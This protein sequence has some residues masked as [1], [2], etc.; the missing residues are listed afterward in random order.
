M[1]SSL[2]AIAKARHVSVKPGD[3]VS[4]AGDVLT[5]GEGKPFSA[6]VNGEDLTGDQMDSYKARPRDSIE[7]DD[8][9]DIM[10]DYDVQ[11]QEQQ[12]V[13]KMEGS[14]GAVAYVEQWGQV[15]KVEQRTG[16]T[17]G[18][19]AE[20]D[21]LQEKKDCVIRA[22]N[23]HPADGQRLVALTFDDGPSDP[24]TE[25]YL[26]ILQQYDAK[27]TFFCLGENIEKYPELAKR[28]TDAGMQLCSHTDTHQDLPSLSSS[29]L[30]E[31]INHT[32]GTIKDATGQETTTIRPPY[33][34]FKEQTWLDSRGT[35]S[36][37]ITWNMD[38][39]DWS[40]PGAE[41]IVSNATTGIQPGYIILMHDGGGDRSQDVEALPQ[42][43]KTLQDQGYKFV[44]VSEL[45]ASEGD[46][47]SDVAR[48]DAHMPEGAVWPD[49]ISPDDLKATAA[50][51]S[52]SSSTSS[53]SSSSS[54][55]ESDGE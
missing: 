41:A 42:I 11:V 19:T 43:I 6:K 44:T 33:G 35:I 9:A 55:S 21:T 12:P 17:S 53:S 18:K 3:Y 13:L 20:G 27:A 10:E 48:G 4:V 40:L 16:K 39:R 37:S 51:S 46:I 15:G 54:S 28:I 30:V 36:A 29:K 38:S 14:A 5:E 31:E 34:S 1:G 26:S 45:L 49:K 47:P 7:F 8:G 32:F 22:R 25:Q 52:S 23:V 50:A 2:Q 24:Y